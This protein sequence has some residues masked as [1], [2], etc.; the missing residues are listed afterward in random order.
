MGPVIQVPSPPFGPSLWLSP[1]CLLLECTPKGPSSW[2]MHGRTARWAGDACGRGGLAHGVGPC[3][4]EDGAC[5]PAFG[6]S[7]P[8]L[9]SPEWPQD[10]PILGG[11]AAQGPSPR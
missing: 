11:S 10:G 5:A 6:D 7:G 2:P 1:S 9:C 4:S 8:K 3:S